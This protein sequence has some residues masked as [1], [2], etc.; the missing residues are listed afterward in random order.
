[1]TLYAFLFRLIALSVVPLV[2]LSGYFAVNHYRTLRAEQDSVATNLVNSVA[3]SIDQHLGSRIGAL[4]ML[5]SSPL[6]RNA[7]RRDDLYQE[8]QG[9]QKSFGSH[10]ILADTERHMLFNTRVPFGAPLP[11]LPKPEGRAAAPIAVATGQPAVG[12][13]F[14]GPIAKESLVAI[15]VPAQN[16]GRTD[17][18]LL[19]V[20]ETRAFQ[21]HINRVSLPSGW[22][23]SL[24]DSR[25]EVIARRAPSAVDSA[26]EPNTAERFVAGSA[27]SPWSVVLE[28]PRTAF[29]APLISAAVAMLAALLVATVVSVWAGLWASRRLTGAV[30]SLVEPPT[31]GGH[32]SSID[33][34]AA[35]RRLL[36]ETDARRMSAEN[37]LSKSEMRFKATFEQAAVG[38]ALVAPD[39]HWLQVNNK[40]CEIVGYGR[41]ELL[42]LG[43]QD[44]THPDDLDT[45]LEYVRQMM[46]R[47]IESYAMEKRYLNKNGQVVWVNLTV[48]LIWAPDGTPDYFISVVEDIQTRKE[49]E[50]SLAAVVEEQRRGR[51]AALNQMEDAIAAREASELAAVALRDSEQRFR[52]AFEQAAVG[53]AVVTP[54]GRWLRTNQ[55]LCDIVG[56]PADELQN[57]ASQEITHP[58][59]RE[60]SR[61]WMER[62]LAGEVDTYTLEK[63]HVRRDGT[64]VWVNTAVSLVR[65]ADGRPNHVIKVIEDIQRR[66]GAEESLNRSEERLRL[67]LDATNDGL[68]DWDL[69]SGAVYRS[70]RYFELVGRQPNDGTP[71][72]GFFRSV[73][74]PDDLP[75]V[76]AVIEAHKQGRTAAIEF[77]FRLAGA[78]EAVKW[79]GVR[80]RAVE[81]DDTGAP[82]RIVGTLADISERKRTEEEIRDLN[83][84]LERRVVERTAELTVANRELDSFAYAV[85][86][87]LRAPLRAMSGFSQALT[88]DYGDALEGDAKLY[89]DQ[90][91]VASRKMGELIDGI[92]ALSRSTRGELQC[93]AID[94]SALAAS[95]VGELAH[96]EPGRVVGIEIEQGL[97]IDGDGRMIEA[98]MHNLLS[99]AWKYTGK[100]GTPAIRV[101]SGEIDGWQGICVADNGAGFDMAHA[102]QLF[103]PFRRLHRQDEFPGIGIGLATVQRIIRRHGG[104]IRAYAE[105]GKGATFCF[106]LSGENEV[107]R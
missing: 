69:R 68:W 49:A 16:E 78:G 44:I 18:L 91:G 82:L 60:D 28:I 2:L 65:H 64:V 48:A 98:V 13:V 8:A 26:A 96:A 25:G 32:S 102:D 52:A 59:D 14:Q 43:F 55:K 94:L 7:S 22:G 9:F 29:Q 89:L 58:D 38:I 104:E 3:T 4:Q 83:T 66:K 75:H 35:V 24:L 30:A 31:R 100:T 15:A 10:V 106:T 88:E 37:T 95:V 1:M 41:E 107:P 77:E 74:H 61:R 57:K 34:I 76:L 86:H 80:G 5:A 84:D 70:P 17:Y 101:Y 46:N 93:N 81:R 47:E 6:L 63:R 39:G 21:G 20:Y 92:L 19:T 97:V 87:D 40:L 85:S 67:A 103:Q 36:D 33:E 45:D 51:L 90:I 42:R 99:N 62:L 50:G 71:D 27:V 53:M 23:V 56:Y 72:F 105:P 11:T 12:D 79:L 73:V 54:D